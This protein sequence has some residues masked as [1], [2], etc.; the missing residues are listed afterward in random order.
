[1]SKKY[2]IT[3]YHK[4]F[5]GSTSVINITDAE[6]DSKFYQY[7][8]NCFIVWGEKEGKSVYYSFPLDKI[9]YVNIEEC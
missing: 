9:N 7:K 2:L 6:E 5:F 1:M 8:D 3:M 4:G